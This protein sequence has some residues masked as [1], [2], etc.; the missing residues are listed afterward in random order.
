MYLQSRQKRQAEARGGWDYY[1][2]A[3][4]ES[5]STVHFRAGKDDD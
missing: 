1:G 3:P 2:L 4:T 5:M